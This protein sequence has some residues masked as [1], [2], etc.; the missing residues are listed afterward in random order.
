MC[1]VTTYG[2]SCGHAYSI[3][4]QCQ[5]PGSQICRIVNMG[6]WNLTYPCNYCNQP[7]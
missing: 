1:Q 6:A 2:Y 4:V 7:R 3:I 5:F